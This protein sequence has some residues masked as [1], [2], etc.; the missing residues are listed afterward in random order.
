MFLSRQAALAQRCIG[1][2]IKVTQ[3]SRENFVVRLGGRGDKDTN[4][5]QSFTTDFAMHHMEL[6]SKAFVTQGVFRRGMNVELKQLK[7]AIDFRNLECVGLTA[8]RRCIGLLD[9]MI[10]GKTKVTERTGSFLCVRVR[11]KSESVGLLLDNRTI[12]ASKQVS[13][14]AGEVGAS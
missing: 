8:I 6:S 1:S 10:N 7:S 14:Q 4:H 11:V 2:G 5:G 3:E 13:R 12:G 9:V